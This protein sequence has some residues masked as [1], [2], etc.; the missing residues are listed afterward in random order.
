MINRECD[1][2]KELQE[3]DLS[4]DNL[5][6]KLDTLPEKE[7]ISE[8]KQEVERLKSRLSKEEP[9]LEQE[10][11]NQKKIE[12]ELALLDDKL[13][14]EQKKLYAGNI[15]NPKELAG[16]QGEVSSLGRQKDDMETKL[17]EQL[18]A[19]DG[20][21][22]QV[23]NLSS[24]LNKTELELAELE[25]ERK[26]KEEAIEQEIASLEEDR[27]KVVPE[28]PKEIFSLY[29]KL[30][31]EKQGIAAVEIEEGVCS[32]CH[33]DLPSEEVDKMMNSQELWRCFQCG[34]ILL[35]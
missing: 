3:T 7:K 27:I 30:R 13:G 20:L 1:L 2:L 23:D 35:R 31:Q 9:C 18:D 5:K 8:V 17:L 33:I 25:K 6:E 34:R 16:I 24:E 12:D 21:A 29:Q 19:V 26:K 11:H 28:L 10:R 32:G 14:R 15:T 22:S 4:I